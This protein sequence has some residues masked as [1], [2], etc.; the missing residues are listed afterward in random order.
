MKDISVYVLITVVLY[1][2]M[3]TQMPDSPHRSP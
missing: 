3:T 1:F 2:C